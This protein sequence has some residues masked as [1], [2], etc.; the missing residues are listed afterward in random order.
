M[1]GGESETRTD[2]RDITP[3]RPAKDGGDKKALYFTAAFVALLIAM[4]VGD[5]L[6]GSKL[7]SAILGGCVWVAVMLTGAYREGMI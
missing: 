7:L 5:I 4:P 2:G 6:L 1:T 3:A